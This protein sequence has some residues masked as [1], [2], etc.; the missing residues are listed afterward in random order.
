MFNIG[1]FK[2]ELIENVA[3]L[4][5]ARAAYANSART[6][7][8][9]GDSDAD[10]HYLPALNNAFASIL[11]VHF[12]RVEKDLTAEYSNGLP[13]EITTDYSFYTYEDYHNRNSGRFLNYQRNQELLK[14]DK[15]SLHSQVLALETMIHQMPWDKIKKHFDDQCENVKSEGMRNAVQKVNRYFRIAR[16]RDKPTFKKNSYVISRYYSGHAYDLHTDVEELGAVIQSLAPITTEAS[17]NV[18]DSLQELRSALIENCQTRTPIPMRTRFGKGSQMDITVF[19]SKITFSL[20]AS[21]VEAIQSATIMYGTDEDID[22]V[23]ALV[24]SAEAA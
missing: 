10:R 8:Q 12:E 11:K 16:G 19:K 7:R 9:L 18:G 24:A 22:S 23:M 15:E 14:I 13:V 6:L 4:I 2:K 5:E 3:K 17:V 21:L 20:G 1:A